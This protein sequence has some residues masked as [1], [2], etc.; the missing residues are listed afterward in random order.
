MP[1]KFFPCLF[2]SYD[3]FLKKSLRITIRVSNSLD[4]DCARHSV[5]PDLDPNCLQRL[6]ALSRRQNSLLAVTNIEKLFLELLDWNKE[7]Y[8]SH[9]LQIG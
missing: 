3:D 9:L 5:R 2:S 7:L 1:G 6:S 8:F 4:L